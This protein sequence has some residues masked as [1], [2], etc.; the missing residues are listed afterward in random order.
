[1]VSVSQYRQQEHKHRMYS[2]LRREDTES[3]EF[4]GLF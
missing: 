2:V 4:G 3:S 1:M